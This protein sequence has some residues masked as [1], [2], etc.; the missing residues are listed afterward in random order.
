MDCPKCG[1]VMTDLEAECPRCKRA[2]DAAAPSPPAQPQSAAPR[3]AEQSAPRRRLLAR[4]QV[5]G[6]EPGSVQQGQNFRITAESLLLVLG[7]V[8]VGGPLSLWYCYKAEACGV[9][10]GWIKQAAWALT[11]GVPALAF[12]VTMLALGNAQ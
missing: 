7:A 5:H 11:I 6:I 1:Y 9:G 12:I 8:Y 4:D 10:A 2:G 3:I